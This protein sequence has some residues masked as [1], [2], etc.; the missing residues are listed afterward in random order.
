MKIHIDLNEKETASS[1]G[2]KEEVKHKY[3]LGVF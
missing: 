1:Y 2:S 3:K